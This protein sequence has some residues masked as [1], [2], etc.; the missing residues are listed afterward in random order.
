MGCS[1]ESIVSC[2][3]LRLVDELEDNDSLKV[4]KRD[5]KPANTREQIVKMMKEGLNKEFTYNGLV[6]GSW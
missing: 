5:G 6:R 1:A 2:A 4:M 3:L